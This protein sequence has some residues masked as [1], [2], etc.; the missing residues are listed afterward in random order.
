MARPRTPTALKELKGTLQPCR[1]NAQE[2]LLELGVPIAPAHLSQRA[3]R[4]WDYIAQSLAAMKVLTAADGMAMEEAAQAYADLLDAREALARPIVV[5]GGDEPDAAPPYV[6]A[7]AG[8]L[9]YVTMGKSGP[10][11]RVRPEKALIADASRRLALWLAKLGMSPADRSRV[12]GAGGDDK[13]DDPWES[14]D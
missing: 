6:V 8:S 10:M 13:P 7:A 1:S 4:A 11:V 12:S 3:R 14:F 2:P 9:T 5:G